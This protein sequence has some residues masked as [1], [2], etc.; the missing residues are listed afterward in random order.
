MSSSRSIA[1]IASLPH[2]LFDGTLGTGR[3]ISLPTAAAGFSG[4]SMGFLISKRS[5]SIKLG[6]IR[7]PGT[8]LDFPREQGKIRF[9]LRKSRGRREKTSQNQ[10]PG[11]N[12]AD[13][14][15]AESQGNWQRNLPAHC[16]LD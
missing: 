7:P 2:T 10:R 8:R 14:P 3:S 1:A 6:G 13:R 11:Y 5:V 16:R 12:L 4:M 9:R 15:A